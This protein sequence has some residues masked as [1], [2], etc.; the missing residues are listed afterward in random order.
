MVY[1]SIFVVTSVRLEVEQKQ[2]VTS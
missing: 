1:S 2:L